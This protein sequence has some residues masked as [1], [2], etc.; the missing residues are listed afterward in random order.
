MILIESMP[1]EIVGARGLRDRRHRAPKSR[2]DLRDATQH[3][4]HLDCV[5]QIARNT[6]QQSVFAL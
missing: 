4:T 2:Q 3:P 1:L 5:D 6:A